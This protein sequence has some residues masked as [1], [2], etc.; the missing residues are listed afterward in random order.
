M[1]DLRE[2]KSRN[3]NFSTHLAQSPMTL[4]P[5][6]KTDPL[7]G[8][9]PK[10]ALLANENSVSAASPSSLV[11]SG[12]SELYENDTQPASAP[13]TRIARLVEPVSSRTRT[14]R[15]EIILLR[16]SIVNGF[17]CAPWDKFPTS[18]DFALGDDH[19]LFKWVL[20]RPLSFFSVPVRFL[21][22]CGTGETNR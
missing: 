2:S 4:L 13:S 9:K 20:P 3:G 19:Y 21:P 6:D 11:N 10:D 18:S 14:R 8:T 12:V 1:S 5:I 7:A 22:I 15:E 16:A 17:K